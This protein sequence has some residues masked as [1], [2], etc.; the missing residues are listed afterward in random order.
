MMLLDLICFDC[1]KDQ[2][3]KGVPHTSPGQQILTPYEPVNNSGI[4]KVNCSNGHNA[5]TVID[6]IDFEILFEYGINAIADGY[7]REAVSTLT[8]AMERYFEFFIKTI[9]RTSQSD[10]SKIDKTWKNISSQSE[11]QLGAYIISYSQNF[12]EDPLLLNANKDVP[13]RNSVIHKGYIPT[14]EEAVEYGNSVL[15]I[16]ETSLIKLKNMFSF[17]TNET[18][19]YYGYKRAGEENIKKIERETGNEQNFACVNIMTTI[20]VKNG[21]E[22]NDEDVRKGKIEDRI[23]IILERRNPRGLTLSKDI[24]KKNL[25]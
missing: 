17:E 14:K 9:L 16:I 21:R 2:I 18:F 20:D 1:L 19:D 13:F 23:P 25:E 4:Y 24:P 11:R 8:S 7:Y 10:F 5:T 3:D 6:N 15:L 12:G 22:I